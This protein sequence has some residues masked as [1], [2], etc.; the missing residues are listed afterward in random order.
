MHISS[1]PGGA[2]SRAWWLGGFL[3]AL[4]ALPVLTAPAADAATSPPWT[5]QVT[6]NPGKFDNLQGV[7]CPSAKRC[8]AAGFDSVDASSD[9]GVLPETW[10]GTIWQVP[11]LV[12]GDP[13]GSA[14]SSFL[15]GV[16][17]PVTTKC[18]MVGRFLDSG[19]N[20]LPLAAVWD[21]FLGKASVASQ[22]VPLPPGATEAQLSGVSC[23][24]VNACIAVGDFADPTGSGGALAERWDGS[25]WQLLQSGIAADGS[26]A[27]L[28][29]VSCS[30]AT[31]CMAVGQ[32]GSAELAAIWNGATW[33]FVLGSN[34][35]GVP[36]AAL[37][38]VSCTADG[39]CMAVGEQSNPLVAAGSLTLAL[40]WIRGQFF[41]LNTA[42][43]S[44]TSNVLHGVSCTSGSN[45]LTVGHFQDFR[46]Q[47]DTLAE[48]W[49]GAN[50]S[51]EST[52]NPAGTVPDLNG[53]SCSSAATCT[54]V[55]IFKSGTGHFLTL[56]ERFVAAGS[57]HGFSLTRNGTVLALLRQPRTL[58][59]LVFQRGRHGHLLGPV[60]LGSHPRGLS[61]IRWNLRVGGKRL[62]PGSYTAELVAAF[63]RSVT[64][65]G[66]S[67]TFDL[68]RA[69]VVR[70]RSATCSVAAAERGR[71]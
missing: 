68:T 44:Q 30:S 25:R 39:A 2:G 70:V 23:T 3:V 27:Q 46:G 53:V 36:F 40:K 1:R 65:D 55:G 52:P 21:G 62:L 32:H 10:D 33:L 66:P 48:Q 38:G 35:N 29:A 49:D 59:L 43:P 18:E 42:N 19:G 41:L 61:R 17:C 69:G 5:I 45:C 54:A 9:F 15:T 63:G 71:C 26:S 60:A 58:E 6:Q 51:F 34:F 31:F 56:A 14:S 64:S 47:Q 57:P 67:V 11:S 22:P 13:L 7:S 20:I 28:N 24:S 8:V 16:S 50:W 4:M 37:N 12:K